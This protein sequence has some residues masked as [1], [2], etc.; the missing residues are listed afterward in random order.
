MENHDKLGVSVLLACC[1][2]VSL[3]S[4]RA[5][6]NEPDAAQLVRAV[7][8]TEMWMRD[9]ESLHIR[10]QARWTRAPEGIARRRA[11]IKEEFGI[12]NP[13]ITQFPDLRDALEQS[14]EIAV[15]PKR[16]RFL[17]DDP[18][19]WRQLKVWDG[20]ELRIHE[21]YYHR[22][23]ELYVL[24]SKIPDWAFRELFPS[25][26]GW[27][28][29]QLHSFWYDKRDV[30]EAMD[31][32]GR[33]EDFRL[34][35]QEVY[36]K[37]ACYVLEFQVP[38]QGPAGLSRRWFVGRSDGLLHGIQTLREEG[39][40]VEHWWS[41][42]RKV[43][44]DGWFPW[45]SNWCFYRADDT[46]L[47]QIESTCNQQVAELHINEPLSDE[48]FVLPIEPEVEVVDVMDSRS[49]QLRRYKVHR[50]WPSLLG[51][52]LRDFADL[53]LA[54]AIPAKGKAILIVFVDL[55]NRPSRH[56]L[57]ELAKSQEVFLQRCVEVV[58]IEMS[59]MT[60]EALREWRETLAIPWRIGVTTGDPDTVRRS[61]GAK[62]LPWLILTDRRHLVRA[63]GFPL[64]ELDAK[65]AEGLENQQQ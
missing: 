22:V 6:G 55:Q 2:A 13:D 35:G 26:Y 32:Y 39:P 23:H 4:A 21:K 54:S 59:D 17:T 58:P 28:R 14:L 30:N 27:P 37:V 31:F 24:D 38:A 47:M 9:C 63:E 18:G 19:Y 1:T 57:Q 40:S 7:R 62:S 45:K 48:L 56:A 12:E 53:K 61:W 42:Y 15:D 29:S 46:G 43:G 50:Q 10:V 16:I 41:D 36:R 49:G 44:S 51:K 60:S 34:V 25:C 52:E 20:N 64:E 5:Y 33:A 8:K 11:Q 3:L 65:L